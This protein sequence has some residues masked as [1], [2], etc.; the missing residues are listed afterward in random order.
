MS[1]SKQV[2]PRFLT[3]LESD[4]LYIKQQYEKLAAFM[5]GKSSG[6]MHPDDDATIYEYGGLHLLLSIKQPMSQE[7]MKWLCE[8]IYRGEPAKNSIINFDRNVHYW[9]EESMSYGCGVCIV[10]LLGGIGECFDINVDTRLKMRIYIGDGNAFMETTSDEGKVYYFELNEFSMIY[11]EVNEPGYDMPMNEPANG[12]VNETD[13]RVFVVFDRSRE[14]SYFNR[15]P[16]HSTP[17]AMSI[18]KDEGSDE[19]GSTSDTKEEVS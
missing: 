2:A 16:L 5:E 4:Y 8:H 6:E 19:S 14:L 9:N 1:K 13:E 18:A 3:K 15:F 17:E 11:N 10:E 12:P 7:K